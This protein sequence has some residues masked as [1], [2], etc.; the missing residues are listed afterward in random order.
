[1]RKGRKLHNMARNFVSRLSQLGL[2]LDIPLSYIQARLLQLQS[3]G[4]IY[5]QGDFLYSVV[6]YRS[7]PFSKHHRFVMVL[8]FVVFQYRIYNTFV[9]MDIPVQFLVSNNICNSIAG[10]TGVSTLLLFKSV[11]QAACRE[12]RTLVYRDSIE[13]APPP[14]PPTRSH[15]T[16]FYHFIYM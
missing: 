5:M 7:K 3:F 8:G 15:T 13:P 11:R 6:C 12:P 1:M 4:Y 14:P 10:G 16:G 9:H 2:M